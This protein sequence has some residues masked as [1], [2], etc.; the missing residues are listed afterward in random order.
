M[1]AFYILLAI[2]ITYLAWRGRRRRSRRM[3][4]PAELGEVLQRSRQQSRH[5]S[6]TALSGE[7]GGEPL[8]RASGD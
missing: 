8:R 3:L 5:A 6:R 1:S 4:S 2:I 7:S